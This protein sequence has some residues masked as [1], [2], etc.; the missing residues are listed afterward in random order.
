MGNGCSFFARTIHALRAKAFKPKH[1]ESC[2]S[3]SENEREL[4]KSLTSVDLVFLGI[5]GI[6][7][8]GVFVLTG[9]AAKQDAGYVQPPC[10]CA[11]LRATSISPRPNATFMPSN[12]TTNRKLVATGAMSAST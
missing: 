10:L 8:A 9:T 4:R 3:S 7:G 2:S 1:I 11:R 6:I 5:G 12:T